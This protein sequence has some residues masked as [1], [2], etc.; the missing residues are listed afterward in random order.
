[1][2][3][4]REARPSWVAC[5]LREVAGDSGSLQTAWDVMRVD[6]VKPALL[7]SKKETRA[8]RKPL[9]SVKQEWQQRFGT[10]ALSRAAG[11]NPC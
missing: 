10:L 5:M 2:D 11:L 3:G 8:E 4:M 6:S 7:E 1:M 9:A